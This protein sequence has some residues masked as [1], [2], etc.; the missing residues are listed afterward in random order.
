MNYSSL[1]EKY[2]INGVCDLVINEIIDTTGKE[3]DFRLNN[4]LQVFASTKIARKRMPYHI[5]FFRGDTANRLSYIIAHECGHIS[6]MYSVSPDKRVV[7]YINN[8]LRNEAKKTIK[9]D[10]PE[11]IKNQMVNIWIDGIIMQVTNLPVDIQIEG[12]IKK[13]LPEIMND[14]KRSLKIDAENNLQILSERIKKVTPENIYHMSLSMNYAYL[15]Y[16]GQITDEN[17]ISKFNNNGVVEKGIKL[18]DSLIMNTKNYTEDIENINK[19]AEILNIKEWFSWINY[20]NMPESYYS[21]I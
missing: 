2:T 15:K 10:L 3:I 12:S 8:K 11:S 7:P 18:Y 19:W 6:K 1:K 9:I 13:Y 16:I 4:N 21:D 17:Y 14:Q 5:I 20:E